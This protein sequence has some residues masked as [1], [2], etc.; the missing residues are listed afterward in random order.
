MFAVRQVCEKHLGNMKDVF[1]AFINLKKACDTIDG[2]G[3]WQ[4]L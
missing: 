1:W 2:H 3:M 4:M